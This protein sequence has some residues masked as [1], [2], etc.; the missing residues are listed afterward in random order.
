MP[1]A[2][3][4]IGMRLEW[5][6]MMRCPA[7]RNALGMGLCVG[8]PRR[9]QPA[10]PGRGVARS[11][12]ILSCS[13]FAYVNGFLPV[14]REE[15]LARGWGELDFV[16]VTGDAYVD[17]PSFGGALIARLLESRGYRIGVIPQPDWRNAESF[18]LLGRPRLGFL[19][20]SGNVDSMV[21][22]F[23]SFRHRRRRD[24]YSPGGAVGRRPDRAVVVYAHCARQAYPGVTV[25]IGGLEASLRRFS[26]YDYWSDTVRRSVLLDSKA[27]LL[28]YGMGEHPIL[29]IADQLSRG[30]P[31]REITAVRG[32]SYW[33]S[34][35]A[36]PATG[37]TAK[38]Q[39]ERSV[40]LPSFEMV[41]EDRGAFAESFLLQYQNTDPYSGCCLVEPVSGGRVVQNPPAYPLGTAELDEL[42]ELPY[43]RDYHP[44]YTAQGGVPAVEEVRFSLV[45][46]R[47]CFGACS[48]CSLTFHQGRIVQG[49]SHESLLREAESLVER[50]DF[51]GYIHDVGGPTA[52]FRT[53]ACARQE[54]RGACPDR[55][56]LF[57][58]ICR[59]LNVDH[60][61][62]LELLRKL[63]ALPKV[64]K[65]F[66]RS[67]IR[68]DYLLADRD[69]S[70]FVEMCRHHVSGQLKVAPEHVSSRVLRLMGKPERRVFDRFAERFEAI[71]RNLG[72]EQYLVPYLISSHPG[73]EL[74]DAVELAEYLRDHRLQP[75]QVQDFYPTPG[76]L[77]TCMYHSGLDPRSGKPVYSAKGLHEKALQRALVQY[78][79]P[80]NR[81]LVLEALRKAGR[82]DLIGYSAK[83]LVRP[84]FA[85]GPKQ[86]FEKPGSPKGTRSKR[87]EPRSRDRRRPRRP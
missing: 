11:P 73:S 40:L 29:G 27:D 18:R 24:A 9:P 55:Q 59:N 81:H 46:S 20:T 10:T 21:N 68:Y 74:E 62:Y 5:A 36:G 86:Q 17:H 69:E 45:S 82:F 4:R 33:R 7:H 47:G 25:I 6:W 31:V 1:C 51:R 78:R 38:D 77:S 37:E 44:M 22:H 41:R 70:Y 53:A 16:L 79:L 85:R 42:Y 75:E 19:V 84:E 57:P 63:R 80:Q 87:Q 12:S 66:I 83:C 15:A 35:A 64:K 60:G 72:K 3:L 8:T 71:N 76:T 54:R 56:C 39:F 65:V 30:V 49:R 52:N 28:V 43:T 14:S 23:T 26:H 34:G 67:G 2:A 61:D 48:F 58:D 32:T 50:S 13:I